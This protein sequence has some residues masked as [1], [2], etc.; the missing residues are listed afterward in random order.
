MSSKVNIARSWYSYKGGEYEE[1]PYFH[2]SETVI[3]AKKLEENFS[4][5]KEE[6]ENL[7][8]TKGASLDPYFNHNLVDLKKSWKVGEFYFWGKRND[9]LCS[10][11]PTLDRIL[12]SI[13]GFMTAGISVLEPQT[14]IKGHYG[15]TNTTLRGHLGLK[16][17]APYPT[18]GIQAGKEERGWEEG[19]VLLFC[20]A[21]YH[22]AWNHS[23]SVRYVL[24]VDVI[25]EEF[26]DQKKDI[27][28]NVLSLI[29]LQKLEYKYL[30]V[31]KLPGPLRGIIRHLLKRTI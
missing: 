15:D 10:L 23:D 9:E 25:K 16:I 2:T 24:I 27:C 1:K 30:F 4:A 28:A 5:I 19:K 11:V 6:L 17:P 21:N 3:W 22:R 7:M 26:K 29:A 14:D 12:T 20:D 31:V 13:P 8:R 18:C